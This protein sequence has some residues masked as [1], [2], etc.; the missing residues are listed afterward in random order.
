MEQK[1]VFQTFA[2]SKLYK[3]FKED[4]DKVK[5]KVEDFNIYD[6]LKGE[7][8]K[9]GNIDIN[10]ALLKTLENKI[11]KK[12]ELYDEKNKKNEED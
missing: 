1:V 11:F 5:I 3:E 4:F 7:S 2:L 10:N 12:F 8:D 9:G 6:I